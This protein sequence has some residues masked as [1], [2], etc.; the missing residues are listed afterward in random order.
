[1]FELPQLEMRGKEAEIGC[2]EGCVV[3]AE[4]EKVV[5]AFLGMLEGKHVDG[6]HE[7]TWEEVARLS[8]KYD[9][10]IVQQ[11]VQR[12]AWCVSRSPQSAIGEQTGC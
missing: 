3:L 4:P 10:G 11:Y 6:L 12:R 9:S 2:E 7:K 5:V 1:M 8:D